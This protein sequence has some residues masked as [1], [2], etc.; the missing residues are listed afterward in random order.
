MIYHVVSHTMSEENK[1]QDFV[2][3]VSQRKPCS[4]GY[5]AKHLLS[6]ATSR[7]SVPLQIWFTHICRETSAQVAFQNLFC[8]LHFTSFEQKLAQGRFSLLSKWNKVIVGMVNFKAERGKFS[9]LVL[10]GFPF[11]PVIHML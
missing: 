9:A 4:K 8:K 10:T 11:F 3:L 6:T 2:I 5:V 1:P 7:A